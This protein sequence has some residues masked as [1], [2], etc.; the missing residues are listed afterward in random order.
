MVSP[1]VF[2]GGVRRAEIVQLHHLSPQVDP[3]VVVEDDVGAAQLHP[4]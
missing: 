3:Q 1:G 4:L 2:A